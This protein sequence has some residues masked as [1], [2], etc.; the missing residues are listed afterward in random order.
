MSRD[1]L[2]D[3]DKIV[4]PI[5]HYYGNIVRACFIIASFMLLG[6]I[7]IDWRLLNF[8]LL[9]GVVGIVVLIVLAG[10]TNPKSLK[11][12]NI[13]AGVSAFGFIFFEYAAIIAFE[14]VQDFSNL[15]FLFRQILAI[16]FLV[17]LYYS[18]KSIRW[19]RVLQN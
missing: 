1:F 19:L 5:D 7:L 12:L 17:A 14:T 9:V 6:T 15:T 4:K 3:R 18:I 2:S 11:V 8:Y 16:L 10:L 13:E